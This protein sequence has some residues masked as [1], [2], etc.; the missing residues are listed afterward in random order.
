[1]AI[2]SYRRQQT[3]NQTRAQQKAQ[4]KK[5]FIQQLAI[6]VSSESYSARSASEERQMLARNHQ[7][8][9][10]A[11]AS[12]GHFL[13]LANGISLFF[14]SGA[15]TSLSAIASLALSSSRAPTCCSQRVRRASA[16]TEP[17][18]V[19]QSRWPEAASC[20]SQLPSGSVHASRHLLR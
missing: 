6:A 14:C 15:S 13:V 7:L 2:I 4:R 1:M 11:T 20:R 9:V 5:A 17:S 12:K 8:S 3:S 10:P 18:R 16:A 19:E